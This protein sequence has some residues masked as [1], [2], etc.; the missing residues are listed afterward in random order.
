MHPDI[1][2]LV[3]AG[4]LR[5][6]AGVKLSALE[7]GVFV[8][9]KSW[10]FGRITSW[11]VTLEQVTIDF[12]SK[13]GHFMQFPFAA[14]TLSPLP[15]GHFLARKMSDL[16]GM[17]KMAKEDPRSVV[18][19]IL[20]SLGGKATIAQMQQ[21][22]NSMTPEQ[23]AQLQ[24][25]ANALLDDMDLRWQV[26]QLGQN[27]RG[28]FPQMG[29]GQGMRFRGDE[30]L[31]LQGMG[32]L[33][34]QLGDIDALENLMRNAT[35]P[36][37]LAEHSADLFTWRVESDDLIAHASRQLAQRLA[38]FAAKPELIQICISEHC[39]G[40]KEVTDVGHDT[41][42]WFAESLDQS[43]QLAGVGMDAKVL[44]NDCTHAALE[45]VPG[46]RNAQSRPTSDE[47]P[48]KRVVA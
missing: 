24:E 41:L 37:Q 13:K 36:G 22:M 7:P 33:L 1:K 48:Q 4:K 43:P 16:A 21:L 35:N 11:D 10:G 45:R 8:Q 17:Q 32:S 34:D 3:E 12:V 23:R 44:C 14:E 2:K 27:L 39:W 26:E 18:K 42:D 25:M 5:N 6:D 28:A 46:A 30:P 40:R 31:P 20:E 29:W 9:H 19:L 38:T 47:W 15:A